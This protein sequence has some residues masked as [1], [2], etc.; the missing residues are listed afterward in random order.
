MR[1]EIKSN[2]ENMLH[3]DIAS[4][5]VLSKASISICS[6]FPLQFHTVSTVQ[7]V[8]S[9]SCPSLLPGS[10]FGEDGLASVAEGLALLGVALGTGGS[11]EIEGRRG[12]R[13]VD[14]FGDTGLVGLARGANGSGGTLLIGI[15]AVGE[16]GRLKRGSCPEVREKRLPGAPPNG[17]RGLVGW[18]GGESGPREGLGDI[19][20]TPS[21]REP[22]FGTSRPLL[23]PF[24]R[25]C[26]ESIGARRLGSM[27]AGM[28][29]PVVV[30]GRAPCSLLSA[31]RA[32]W[33]TPPPTSGGRTL[34]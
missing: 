5:P 31:T 26:V 30:V 16:V 7:V 14:C 18:N 19:G 17:G 2:L 15:P 28:A 8:P 10:A 24:P 20:D 29:V 22:F 9:S 23:G 1:N 33:P 32:A 3:K 6:T 13:E 4:V 11:L 12:L 21:C 27:A 25:S 34:V